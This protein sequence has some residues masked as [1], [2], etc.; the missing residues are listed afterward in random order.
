M[1]IPV[2]SFRQQVTF[3]T[4]PE[5]LYEQI[6]DAK[7]HGKF[8]GSKAKVSRKVGGEFEL[9][10]GSAYGQNIELIPGRKI[11]HSWRM[12]QDDW[13]EEVM[14]QITFDLQSVDK[15]K[16]KMIFTQRNIPTNVA[17]DFK[18]GWKDYYWKPWKEMF[19]K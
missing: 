9:F 4:T 16:T 13:P 14:S 2:T 17:D 19:N 12:R 5:E 3:N 8:T 7:K 15:G 11:V 1:S 10:D 6:M 18:Q